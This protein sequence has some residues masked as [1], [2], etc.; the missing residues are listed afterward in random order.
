VISTTGKAIGTACTIAAA[1]AVTIVPTA[2]AKGGDGIR[3]A[4]TCDDGSSSKLKVKHD[5]GR[6]G[7]EF[8]VDQ[9]RTGVAWQVELRRDGRL[10]FAGVRTT[11][12]PS[13]SFSVNRK[14]AGGASGAVI[15]ARATRNGEVCTVTAKLPAR[16]AATT[17]AGSAAATAAGAVKL[18]G[19]GTV[20]DNSVH[21]TADA[22]TVD[23]HGGD[24][25]GS[26]DGASGNS[27]RGGGDDGPGDDHG[28]HGSDD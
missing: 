15:R 26:S 14:I 10:A 9:N 1:L 13:G 4:G 8:E 12:A 21:T 27:G 18:R 6:I 16:N 20:D 23:D 24:R 5:D 17:A 3:V 2:A 11:T 28:Q 19:D 7:A 22:G 25:S